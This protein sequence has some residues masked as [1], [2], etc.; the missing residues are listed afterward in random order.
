[1]PRAG[2]RILLVVREAPGDGMWLYDLCNL[3]EATA[4][5]CEATTNDEDQVPTEFATIVLANHFRSDFL[6]WLRPWS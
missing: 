2:A 1:M 3:P 6:V 4:R 5:K